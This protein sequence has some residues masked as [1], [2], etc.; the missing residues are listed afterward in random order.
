MLPMDRAW[1]MCD[2]EIEGTPMPEEYRNFY[3]QI[4][5]KDC[6]KVSFSRA[7]EVWHNVLFVAI[8]IVSL[9]VIHYMQVN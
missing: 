7:N 8:A 4:L 2:Q 1:E 6:H 5:C 3:V 9:R